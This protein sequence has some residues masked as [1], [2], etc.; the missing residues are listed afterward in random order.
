MRNINGIKIAQ[1]D[2]LSRWFD[3]GATRGATHMLVIYDYW[4]RRE[5][6]RYVS[7]AED[8]REVYRLYTRGFGGTVD[9]VTEVYDLSGDRQA[10][11]DE[12]RA[13]H[14]PE[15]LL[16]SRAIPRVIRS[17]SLAVPDQ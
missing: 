5:Y 8:L 10:Q 4:H 2:D 17:V 9:R 6:P 11:L 13:F 15:Y 7:P 16:V 3:E 12:Y 1:L 14:L